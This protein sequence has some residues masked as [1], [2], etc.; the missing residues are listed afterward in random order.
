MLFGCRFFLAVKT[1]L[2]K[3][4]EMARARWARLHT[5]APQLHSDGKCPQFYQSSP[6]PMLQWLWS[7]SFWEVQ[8]AGVQARKFHDGQVLGQQK[9]RA[10]WQH[11]D[12][13]ALQNYPKSSKLL[14]RWEGSWRFYCFHI[15]KSSANRVLSKRQV[16]LGGSART[17]SYFSS[18][19]AAVHWSAMG[20]SG[21][22]IIDLDSEGEEDCFSF[23]FPHW[24]KFCF[25]CNVPEVSLAPL[26][27]PGPTW[28]HPTPHQGTSGSWTAFPTLCGCH[29][30]VPCSSPNLSFLALRSCC[31]VCIMAWP[32][33]YL[34]QWL[35]R[36]CILRHKRIRLGW[37][38]PKG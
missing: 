3:R 1:W 33:L 37:A 23:H 30:F 12:P 17:Q 10:A 28:R 6:A 4:G 5:M 24:F 32:G 34:R 35:P 16:G 8:M 20:S 11:S 9:R 2:K 19:R 25:C 18:N 31:M 7:I 21:D 26:A 22:E 14:W 36:G 15:A 13:L 38:I 27:T 29:G